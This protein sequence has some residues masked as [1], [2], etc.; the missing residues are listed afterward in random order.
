MIKPDSA[1]AALRILKQ[2]KID[3]YDG[4]Q[5]SIEAVNAAQRHSNIAHKRYHGA[6]DAYTKALNQFIRDL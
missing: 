3:A 4:F 6:E 2:A 5:K 1:I